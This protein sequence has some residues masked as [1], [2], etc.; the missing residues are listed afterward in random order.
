[1]RM[2]MAACVSCGHTIDAAAR[3]CPYCGANPKSGEKVDTEAVLREVFHARGDVSTSDSI[4]EYA[5]HRQGIVVTLGAIVLFLVLALL[6][7]FVTARNVNAVTSGPAVPLSEIT[8]VNDQHEAQ[9]QT[10]MP[11]LEFQYDGHPQAM[12]TFIV[13]QGAVTPPEVVAA[14]QAAA[15]QAAAQRAAAAAAQHPAA[16]NGKPA[17][18]ATGPQ[19]RPAPSANAAAQHPPR[20]RQ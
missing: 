3:L 7:Q 12:R 17:A 5:R 8:D 10:P 18:P 19:P 16:A 1:M 13:E 9:Q 6:H 11:P 20:P 2:S 14:Q 4:L 15:Q